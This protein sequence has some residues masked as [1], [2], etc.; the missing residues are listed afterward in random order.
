MTALRVHRAGEQ[1]MCSLKPTRYV[2]SAERLRKPQLRKPGERRSVVASAT[3]T[4][5]T[6]RGP[7]DFMK[8]P[9]ELPFWS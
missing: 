8:E 9:C 2:G 6:E 4:L 3:M 1:L 7:V 5:S